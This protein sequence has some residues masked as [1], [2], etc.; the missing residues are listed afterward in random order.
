MAAVTD[1]AED[2]LAAFVDW[3]VSAAHRDD[4]ASG[5]AVVALGCDV[6]HSGKRVRAA[7]RAQVEG[8]LESLEALLGGDA[9]DR[10]RAT[11]ALSTL[12]GAVLVARAVDDPALSDEILRDV[13]AAVKAG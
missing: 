10:R 9:D 8:Y 6:P 7:Y 4:P 5:C 3:Y 1:G 13:R 2:P 11:V 12:V